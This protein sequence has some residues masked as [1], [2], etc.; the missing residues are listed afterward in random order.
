MLH[1]EDRRS[2][3][4]HDAR[5][6]GFRISSFLFAV[7]VRHRNLWRPLGAPTARRTAGRP[8]IYSLSLAIY[9]TSWTYFGGVGLAASRGLEFTAIYIGPILMFTLGM[10][11]LQPDRDPGQGR[12]TDFDRRL[13]GGALRQEPDGGGDGSADRR[14][15]HDSLHRAA[16]QSGLVIGCSDGRRGAIKPRHARHSFSPTS[17]SS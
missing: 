10:P 3:V 11:I 5:L 17:R 9:C 16:A 12:E 14:D 13:H 15:R 1:P 2:A 7:A 8:I 4:D 6:A